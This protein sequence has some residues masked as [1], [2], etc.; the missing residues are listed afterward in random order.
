MG[1]FF[2]LPLDLRIIGAGGGGAES[3]WGR[4]QNYGWQR[5][6]SERFCWSR[7]WQPTPVFL[8]ENLMDRGASWATVHGGSRIRCDLVTKPSKEGTIRTCVPDNIAELLGLPN[9]KFHSLLW[10][11]QWCELYISCHLG[12]FEW[13]FPLLLKVPSLY[14][15]NIN[16]YFWL[17]SGGKDA[18]WNETV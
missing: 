14:K 1:S 4:S 3:A 10:G 7:K 16:V 15:T 9:P 6:G 13:H 11:L 2:L 5:K 12:R 8:L 17:F 18:H